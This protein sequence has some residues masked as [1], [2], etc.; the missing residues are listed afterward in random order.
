MFRQ[1][2][3]IYFQV[4][5]VSRYNFGSFSTSDVNVVLLLYSGCNDIIINKEAAI[6]SSPGYRLGPSFTYPPNLQCSWQINSPTDRELAIVFDDNFDTEVDFDVL[7]VSH[8][9]VYTLYVCLWGIYVCGSPLPTN[10]HLHEFVTKIFVMN[11]TTCS[12]HTI[13]NCGYT[14]TMTPPPSK[15]KLNWFTVI[16]VI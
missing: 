14:W 9:S 8:F 16:I 12:I 11:Q 6:I 10:L 5:K 15:I 4:T 2:M 1:R 13:W 7:T 3:Y